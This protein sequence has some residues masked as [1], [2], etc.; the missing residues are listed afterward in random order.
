M[1]VIMQAVNQVQQQLQQ[2]L[3]VLKD[4]SLVR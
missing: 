2:K 3:K 1:T 4:R